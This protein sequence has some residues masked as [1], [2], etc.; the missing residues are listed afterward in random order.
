M[1]QPLMTVKVAKKAMEA[2]D[3]AVFELADPAGA[4]L[5]PFSAGAHIDVEVAPGLVRQ[6]SLC[7]NPAER[8]RYLIGVLKDPATRGGSAGMHAIAEGAEIRISEPR[9]HFELEHGATRTLLFAGGI[10]VTPILCMAER[11][12]AIGA[13]FRMHYGA[14]SRSRMAFHDRIQASAFADKVSLHF[15]DGDA[16]QKLDIAA[17]LGSPESGAHVYVCGPG[18]FIEAVLQ[19]AAAKGFP[20]SQVHREYFTVDTEAMFAEGGAFQLK[21]ASSGQVFDIPADQTVMDV[22]RDNGVDLPTSCEQ[23]VCGTCITRVIEGV[24]EHR[25]YY[26]TNDEREKGDQFTPCCSRSK[27]PMLVIDM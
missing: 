18:G 10:G 5:P 9:N 19:A 3:I 23:G 7:N 12:A 13:D 25:D 16:A 17:A 8:S 26:L 11:L 20:D 21:L 4:D 27:T 6:Y 24:P 22:L 14:R 2:E 15:D 1:L